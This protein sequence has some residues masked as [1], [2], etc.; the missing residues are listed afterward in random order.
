MCVCEESVQDVVHMEAQDSKIGARSE[1]MVSYWISRWCVAADQMGLD[2]TEVVN[3][4]VMM[5]VDDNNHMID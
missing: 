2:Q 3:N 1:D 5:D 4:Q